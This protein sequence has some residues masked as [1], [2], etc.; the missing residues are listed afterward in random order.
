MVPNIGPEF[1]E[2]LLSR[3]TNKPGT[4]TSPAA[5]QSSPVCKGLDRPASFRRIT[6]LVL[7]HILAMVTSK[8][9]AYIILICL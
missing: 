3:A 8:W 1:V 5:S 4:H 6:L 2:A 7:S 9:M